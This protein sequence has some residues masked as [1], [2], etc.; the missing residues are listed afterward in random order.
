MSL[1]CQ[2]KGQMFGRDAKGKQPDRDTEPYLHLCTVLKGK[3]WGQAVFETQCCWI[4]V[5]LH[6][7]SFSS[8]CILSDGMA[9][10]IMHR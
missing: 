9:T 2:H 5:F 10:G 8:L 6:I 4:C 1:I 7:L 3:R